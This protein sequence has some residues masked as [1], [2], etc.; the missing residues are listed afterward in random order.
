[1][2]ENSWPRVGGVVVEGC[3]VVASRPG[4]EAKVFKGG[5]LVARS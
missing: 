1:V 5:A 4:R 2:L 3:V